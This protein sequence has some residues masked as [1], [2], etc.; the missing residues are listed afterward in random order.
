[1]KA[2]RK[3]LYDS[4][5]EALSIIEEFYKAGKISGAEVPAARKLMTNMTPDQFFVLGK[6]FRSFSDKDLTVTNVIGMLEKVGF[7]INLV[8]DEADR[9]ILQ[10]SLDKLD[11]I[12]KELTAEPEV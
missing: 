3:I 1:M 4:C 5:L 9:K 2:G 11:S 10:K 12:F 7:Y 6:F 8:Q